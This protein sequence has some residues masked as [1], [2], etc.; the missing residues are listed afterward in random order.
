MND[1][2]EGFYAP[3]TRFQ[4]QSDFRNAARRIFDEKQGVGICCLTDTHDNELMWTHYAENYR[5]IC[6]GV[7][8]AYAAGRFAR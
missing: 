8:P 7:S 5:G 4:N 6:I 2:M 3:S 1:P